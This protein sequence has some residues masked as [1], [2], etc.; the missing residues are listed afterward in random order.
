MGTGKLYLEVLFRDESFE[1]MY[2]IGPTFITNK[3]TSKGIEIKYKVW[4]LRI[5]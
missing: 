3:L 4:V 1:V 5:S 2:H